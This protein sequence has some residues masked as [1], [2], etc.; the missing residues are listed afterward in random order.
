MKKNWHKHY[1]LYG[2]AIKNKEILL[3]NKVKGPYI[4]RFDLPG[5]SL[6]EDESLLEH[7]KREF[8][9]ETGYEI[10]I[11]GL[12]NVQDY[13]INE[14]YLDYECIHHIALFYLV[15]L[16]NKV[17]EVS[18]VVNVNGSSETN[19]SAGICWKNLDELSSKNSSPLVMS[20]V[21]FIEDQKININ[22][23]KNIIVFDNNFI[24]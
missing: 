5:G 21:S 6:R 17:G 10:K 13:K 2:I 8:I 20:V 7:L 11:L 18:C 16:T 3:I 14:P 12:V 23:T 22:E 24:K 1:G 15:E 9:E 4:N 19:D